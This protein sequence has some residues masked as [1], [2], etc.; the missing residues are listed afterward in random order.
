MKKAWRIVLSFGLVSLF[1]DITYEGARG[2]L[3]NY[4]DLLGATATI[5]GFSLSLAEFIGNSLRFVFGYF[6]DRTKRYWLFTFSGYIINLFSIP[7]LAL[8]NR[9]D[10]ALLLIIME[11]FGKSFRTPAREVLLASV[12][13]DISTGKVFGVHEALDQIGAMLGP[14]IA[15]IILYITNV[16]YKITFL[17]F[18]IPAILSVSFLVSAYTGYDVSYLDKNVLKSVENNNNDEL[19]KIYW[20]YVIGISFAILGLFYFAVLLYISKEEMLF[21]EWFV[22]LIYFLIMG[23]D[24]V[25]ALVFGLFYDKFGKIV[26]IVIPVMAI[27]IGFLMSTITQTTVLIA[28]IL[29][30]IAIGVFESVSRGAIADIVKTSKRGFGYGAFYTVSGLA[31]LLSGVIFGYFYEANLLQFMPLYVIITEGLAL[32]FISISSR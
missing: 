2:V 17:F 9:W 14:L 11:R 20:Y 31:T 13:R 23:V 21:P 26:N 19:D 27:F 7:A 32:Y 4:F 5:V 10:L 6:A 30:G 15:S 16:N 24:A 8:V 29:L 18:A 22:P 25:A 3:P 12:T 1:A 28:A